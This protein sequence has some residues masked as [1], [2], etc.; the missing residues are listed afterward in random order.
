MGKTYDKQWEVTGTSGKVWKVSRNFD[1]TFEC[2]CPA[3]TFK[4]VHPRPDCQHILR[5]RIELGAVPKI[6]T[7]TTIKHEQTTVR[8]I[9]FED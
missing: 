1:G 8:E 6:V 3:W 4:K 9:T 7:K 2:S 5:K